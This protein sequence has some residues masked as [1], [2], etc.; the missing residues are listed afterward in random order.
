[1]VRRFGGGIHALT[2]AALLSGFRGHVYDCSALT[3]TKHGPG[4][5][6]GAK[7]L[8]FD[9]HGE[10]LVPDF[11]CQLFLACRIDKQSGNVNAG[12]VH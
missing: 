2:L 1:M 4:C 3:I 11:L 8:T 12:V 5:G 6:L 9:V 7:E 10:Y